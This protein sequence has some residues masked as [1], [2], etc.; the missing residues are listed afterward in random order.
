[1]Q[2][3]LTS[4]STALL[5]MAHTELP[6]SFDW[7]EWRAPIAGER[8]FGLDARGMEPASSERAADRRRT[9][10]EHAVLIGCC[11]TSTGDGGGRDGRTAPVG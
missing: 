7:E 10:D 9:T 1:M 5:C 2:P 3:S 11:S 8:L 4:H 6:V